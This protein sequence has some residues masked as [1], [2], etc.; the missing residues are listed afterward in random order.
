MLP[1]LLSRLVWLLLGAGG[2]LRAENLVSVA[3]RAVP[4]P[5]GPTTIVSLGSA[6]APYA[7]R[8]D[9]V[10][11]FDEAAATWSQSRTLPAGIAAHGAVASARRLWLLT[12]PAGVSTIDR[13]MSADGVPGLEL[14]TLPS[15]VRESQGA[16]FGHSLYLGGVDAEGA[17]HWWSADLSASQPQ[18]KTLSAWAARARGVRSG[19]AEGAWARLAVTA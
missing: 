17:A 9:V 2:V 11:R 10:W 8:S 16:V 12:G 6:D 15:P 18:W 13:L 3:T 4:T 7:I 19:G 14:P 1:P 5:P